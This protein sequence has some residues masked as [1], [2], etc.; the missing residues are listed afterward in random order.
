MFAERPVVTGEAVQNTLRIRTFLRIAGISAAVVVTSLLVAGLIAYHRYSRRLDRRLLSGVLTGSADIYA[1]PLVLRKGDT[2]STDELKEELEAA[3][4][5]VTPGNK[6]ATLLRTP[7][8]TRA[9]SAAGEIALSFGANNQID[10][11]L[12]DGANRDDWV[13]GDPLIFNLSG[14]RAK[15]HLVSYNE[16]PK[17]LVQAVMAAE[18]K[19]FFRHGGLDFERIL[20]AGYVDLRSGRKQQGA[21]T[22]TMQLVR[23]LWLN[24]DK[25]WNRKLSESMMTVHLEHKWSKQ[26]IFA[27]Y[28]NQIF[29]G[30]DSAY[31]IHGFAEGARV[32]FGKDLAEITLPE[33]ALL[34]GMV[35]RP[36]ATN[37][38]RWPERALQRRN[39]VLLLM[40]SNGY[41]AARQY[42]DAANA[43]LGL[44]TGDPGRD[45]SWGA[46]WY[47]DLLPREVGE[48]ATGEIHTTID[49]RLQRA[50]GEAIAD[51][52]REVDQALA[53]I[54]ANNGKHAQ[55]ALIALDPHSGE[56]RALVGGR[57]YSQSQLNHI[58]AER[59]PGSVFK[60]FVYSTAI[61][62][63]LSGGGEILTEASLVDDTSS[64]V[65]WGGGLY[66]PRNFKGESF[67]ILTLRDALAKSDNVAAV[68]VAETAGLRRVVAMAR[69]SGLNDRIRPT[70]SV[71]LGAY[72]VTPLEIAG[73]YT[74]FANGG[75]WVKPHLTSQARVE[76]HQAMDP[77][78]AAVM[79]GM[80]QEVVRSGTAAGIRSRGFI[81]PAAGKTGTSHDGWFAGFTTQLLCIV[82]VGFDDYS[83]LNLE[84]ARSALP[85]WTLFMKK[86]ANFTP[87]REAAAFPNSGL[88]ETATICTETGKLATTDCP[89]IRTALFIPGTAPHENCEGHSREA[90]EPSP[91]VHEENVTD[92]EPAVTH[93]GRLGREQIESG[94]SPAEALET[95]VP[96][97]A[98]GSQAP[99][100]N[101]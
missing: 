82:W 31:S 68:K 66:Q 21:S 45:Q 85:I 22:L 61:N 101:R 26:E 13:A 98:K 11:I 16:I 51:G 46:A 29:L 39:R 44:H 54:P 53:R 18:D 50:A 36:S 14:E 33:A 40:R 84:G 20:K 99:P 93:P 52:M 62:S 100:L 74:A 6:G 12:V 94:R 76:S 8:T 56:I 73:A 60:P 96:P 83:Q 28:S 64:D 97:K 49:L 17:V 58:L 71:A 70:P 5:T 69:N 42:N 30:R 47:T 55:A 38:R 32:Y 59:P 34:A 86:A 19:R 23:G 72:A 90:D 3:G 63:A 92:G 77:R 67:G 65:S 7:A 79:L 25:T 89:K 24:P 57:N 81:L 75:M 2:Y 10:R 48:N 43:P 87:Y 91:I 80:L 1:G 78:V 37:P 4:Y 27:A 9:F 35:Q 41:I 95:P 15:R 88:L